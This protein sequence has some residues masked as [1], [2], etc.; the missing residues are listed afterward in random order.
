MPRIPHTK[1]PK[2][3]NYVID[4]LYATDG[5][6]F[7]LTLLSAQSVRKHVPN[8]RFHLI[9]SGDWTPPS[10]SPI[11]WTSFVSVPIDELKNF[12]NYRV[13][14][15][16]AEFHW[17]WGACVRWFVQRMLHIHQCIY[18]DSDVL[19]LRAPRLN[20]VKTVAAV[21]V[22]NF[23]KGRRTETGDFG[24]KFFNKKKPLLESGAMVLNV[25][26]MRKVDFLSRIFDNAI[27]TQQ[28]LG[29]RFY[30]ENSLLSRNFAE[31][32]EKLPL[33]Y[34]VGNH[35]VNCR[36]ITEE[37]TTF[38]HFHHEASGIRNKE[39][40]MS[41][42]VQ[43]GGR[44][45]IA[46]VVDDSAEQ[47]THMWM[48]MRTVRQFNK[49]V[50]FY[51]ISNR[52]LR[53]D[54]INL[55]CPVPKGGFAIY[56]ARPH[57]RFSDGTMFRF[58]LPRLPID[59]VIYLDTDTNCHGSLEPLWEMT[60]RKGIGALHYTIPDKEPH[61]ELKRK[62]YGKTYNNAGVLALNLDY[63]RTVNFE[64]ESLAWLAPAGI[65][66]EVFFAD[67]TIINLRWKA[68]LYP[69]P[70]AYNVKFPLEHQGPKAIRHFFASQK[71]AQ[72]LDFSFRTI[73]QN[74][75]QSMHARIELLQIELEWLK[76]K[77]LNI[78]IKEDS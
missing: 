66:T 70:E 51:V 44:M 4:Y 2:V 50:R 60:K 53:G 55:V 59:R 63:L 25:D 73:A 47:I 13:E 21:P 18:L 7:A 40:I 43:R 61:A 67:E 12:V 68:I 8:A 42:Y 77:D 69:I 30:A 5:R 37:E 38:Y 71:E 75:R 23:N 64:T 65:P 58:Y 29:K 45:N 46:Y 16:G 24:S 31:F 1:Y 28:A 3:R 49:A 57:T 39:V 74:P 20:K 15:P 62:Y 17:G 35:D 32:I 27:E 34:N 54:F 9:A 33:E 72:I 26:W 41:A 52:P 11:A 14:G 76:K 78:C 10:D 48:S 36:L 6:D 19:C 56:R 22:Q